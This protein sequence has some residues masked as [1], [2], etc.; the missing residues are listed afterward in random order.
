M[1]QDSATIDRKRKDFEYQGLKKT[2]EPGV[3]KYMSEVSLDKCM[4]PR[5][6]QVPF[7]RKSK[8]TGIGK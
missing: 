7:E 8:K 3:G 1:K 4:R 5:V 2:N 6:V